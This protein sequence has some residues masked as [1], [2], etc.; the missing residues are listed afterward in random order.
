M[1]F[2]S[3]SLTHDKN[4]EFPRDLPFFTFRTLIETLRALFVVDLKRFRLERGEV[5][6]LRRIV[7]I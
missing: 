6:R 1:V 4:D 7:R 3:M 5:I 2:I